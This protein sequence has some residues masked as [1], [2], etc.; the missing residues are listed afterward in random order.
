M[1][2]TKKIEE[3]SKLIQI[4]IINTKFSVINNNFK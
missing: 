1:Q 4:R 3:S 2:R